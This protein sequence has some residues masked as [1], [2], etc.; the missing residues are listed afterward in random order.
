M[1]TDWGPVIQTGI[2]AVAALGGG[3]VGAWFQARSQER[4]EQRRLRREERIERQQRRDRAAALLAEV[5]AL[6]KDSLRQHGIMDAVPPESRVM[7][8]SLRSEV[9]GLKD[10]QKVVREQLVAMA[11]GAPSPEVRHLVQEVERAL[12]LSLSS[13]WFRLYSRPGGRV[14]IPALAKFAENGQQEHF[15]ALAL[16]DELIEAL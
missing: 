13:T 1:A 14:T 10:R 4:I 8:E 15:K 11:I 7:R 3:A 16:L 6:L 5:S 9:E 12:D 2:G